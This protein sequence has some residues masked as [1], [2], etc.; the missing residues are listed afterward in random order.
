MRMVQVHNNKRTNTFKSLLRKWIHQMFS[1]GSFIEKYMPG[2]SFI[3][4]SE[5]KILGCQAFELHFKEKDTS[6]TGE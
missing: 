2:S 4:N 6:G 5:E 3:C 1:A